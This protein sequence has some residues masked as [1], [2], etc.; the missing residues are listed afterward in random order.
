MISQET[1]SPDAAFLANDD[2]DSRSLCYNDD[3]TC[4]GLIIKKNNV[5]IVCFNEN[6]LSK[7]L[8]KMTLEQDILNSHNQSNDYK[9]KYYSI[10]FF[11]CLKKDQI[12]QLPFIKELTELKDIILDSSEIEKDYKLY[13]IIL[14]YNRNLYNSFHK[15]NYEC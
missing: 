2:L 7:I 13:R 15:R 9:F 6:S 10:G 5:F 3:R 1:L 11:H 14:F 4:K 12:Y 8:N